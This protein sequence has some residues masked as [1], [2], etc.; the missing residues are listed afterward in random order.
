MARQTLNTA[1]DRSTALPTMHLGRVKRSYSPTPGHARKPASNDTNFQRP[2][3][4]VSEL[5]AW[6][7]RAM[8]ASGF[9]DGS[10]SAAAPAV[11]P[12]AT[13]VAA[14]ARA[15]RSASLWEVIAV[16]TDALRTLARRGISAWRRQRD[17]RATYRALHA[18]D[19]RTLHD[20]GLDS[21]EA[22]SVAAELAGGADRTRVQALMTLRYL[23]I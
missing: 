23:S 22:R 12:D 10:M 19:R 21:S 4:Q 17:E 8:A 11:I 7:L 3:P 16:V 2:S 6:A 13:E 20:I 5:D 18:L 1:Q 9:G 14:S 15:A